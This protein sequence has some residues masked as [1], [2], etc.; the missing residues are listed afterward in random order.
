MNYKIYALDG[1]EKISKR[2]INNNKEEINVSNLPGGFY[3]IS[4]ETETNEV[5]NL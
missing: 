2:K 3:I 1:K 5:I 4:D